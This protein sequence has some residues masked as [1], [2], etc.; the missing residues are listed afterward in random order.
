MKMQ[1]LVALVCTL[2]CA[3]QQA[4]AD[5]PNP[6]PRPPDETS[7]LV[8]AGVSLSMAV[9]FFGLWFVGR[10]KAAKLAATQTLNATLTKDRE[11]LP[12]QR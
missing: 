2:M 12:N 6:G 11:T 4:Q 5:I 3:V 9:V 1:N 7:S 8:L 10:S